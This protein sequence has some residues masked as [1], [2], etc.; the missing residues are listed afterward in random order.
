[1]AGE[2]HN[3]N[4]TIATI[5]WNDVMNQD[6]RSMDDAYLGKVKGLCEPFIVLEK[7]TIK[8][9]KLYIPRSLIENYSGGELYFSITEQEAKDTYRRKS[10][11]TEDEIKQIETITENRIMAS[12]S[13]IE[14]TEQKSAG[15][16]E[17]EQRQRPRT[18]KKMMIVNKIKELKENLATTTSSLTSI[19]MPRID[20]EEITKK[21]T[22]TN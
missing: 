11:P 18:E 10:P 8:K 16:G 5:N 21:L 14:I 19:S 6:T 22:H 9:E 4:K 17:G 7:G 12:R 3:N 2:R 15:D 1:M 13:D 20:K